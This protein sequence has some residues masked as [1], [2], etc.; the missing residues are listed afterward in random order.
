MVKV[1][2]GGEI[3]LWVATS[4]P[5]L[6]WQRAQ[7]QNIKTNSKGPQLSTPKSS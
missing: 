3:L 2:E 1:P 5:K 4:V 6:I 7:H